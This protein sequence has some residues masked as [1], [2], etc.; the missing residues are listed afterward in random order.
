MRPGLRSPLVVGGSGRWVAELHGDADQVV[1]SMG[2]A[3]PGVSS[4]A[5]SGRQVDGLFLGQTDEPHDVI[6][7]PAGLA[8]W[9]R[10]DAEIVKPFH[11]EGFG[12]RHE[13]LSPLSRVRSF[14]PNSSTPTP[15]GAPFATPSSF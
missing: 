14:R 6:P 10:V 5:A 7:D 1:L 9:L 3:T 11:C 4:P 13:R 15:S 12:G 8:V 2:R